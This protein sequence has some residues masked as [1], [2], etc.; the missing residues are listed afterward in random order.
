MG[1][2]LEF[3]YR[4][5]FSRNLGWFNHEDQDKIKNTTI[6]IPGMGGV[7]GQHLH[8][9]IRLGFEKFKIADFDVFETHNFNR[10]LGSSMKTVGDSKT[11]TLKELVLDINPNAKIETFD[12]GVNTQNVEDFLN[13]V[14]ILI[15]GL[16]LYVIDIRI[17]LFER[18]HD[19]KIPVITAAP[20]GMGTAVLCFDPNGMSFS[21]YFDLNYKLPF[22]E[23]LAR[24]LTGFAP[25]GLHQ[26]YM[27]YKEFINVRKGEVPSLHIGCLSASSIAS[28]LATKITLNRGRIDYAPRGVHMDLYHQKHKKFWVPF[29]NGNP[30]QKLKIWITKKLL[31]KIDRQN[32]S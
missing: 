5:A 31:E 10:Q 14:D 27:F 12:M 28:S 25:K 29:G 26:N 3:D 21:E 24:F 2:G 4:K 15:D 1:L 16:D 6:A 23:K 17:N 19:L 9:L 7:G 11:T 32:D 18:A 20:L 13:N 8:A 30:Y 22:Y